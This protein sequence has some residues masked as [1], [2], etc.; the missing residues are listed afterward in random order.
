M[1]MI[2]IWAFLFSN[3]C[4]TTSSD[5]WHD[6]TWQKKDGVKNDCD[7]KF[8]TNAYIKLSKIKITS[9]IKPQSTKKWLACFQKNFA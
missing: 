2:I 5:T 9:T 7:A 4:R 8:W 3:V 1:E 6:G